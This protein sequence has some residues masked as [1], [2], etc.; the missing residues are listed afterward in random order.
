MIKDRGRGQEKKVLI[1]WR[2]EFIF[3]NKCV[4]S[5]L[6]TLQFSSH[7]LYIPISVLISF[8]LNSIKFQFSLSHLHTHI[9]THIKC[10]CGQCLSHWLVQ[11]WNLL[12]IVESFIGQCYEE[13]RLENDKIGE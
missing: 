13:S 1:A 7:Y 8:K 6:K 10:S 3:S 11:M 9:H 2:K 5:A 4:K 12:I